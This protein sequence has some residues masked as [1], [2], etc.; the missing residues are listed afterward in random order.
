MLFERLCGIIL[1]R[2]FII[3]HL[4]MLRFSTA[5]NAVV[6]NYIG[7]NSHIILGQVPENG[8]TA[9]DEKNFKALN[10]SS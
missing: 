7:K 5:N 2:E 6:N 4:I 10:T 1:S 8:I 9:S 3:E